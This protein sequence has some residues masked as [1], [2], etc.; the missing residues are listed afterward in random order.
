MQ[1]P[2]FLA[3]CFLIVHFVTLSYYMFSSALS[4]STNI[5]QPEDL[6]YWPAFSLKRISRNKRQKP[7]PI[8]CK[9]N[10]LWEIKK[11]KDNFQDLLEKSTFLGISDQR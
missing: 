11:K 9:I 3:L 10:S 4:I 5:K 1:H 6:S 8:C 7:F 2:L